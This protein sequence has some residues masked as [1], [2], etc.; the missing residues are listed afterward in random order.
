M[1]MNF[2]AVISVVTS[3][4]IYFQILNNKT[5]TISI[6][7][8][9][10][11]LPYSI[12]FA[13]SNSFVEEVI[14]RLGLVVTLK[15]KVKDST[16]CYLSAVIFGIAHYGGNPGGI[17]GVLVTG[18]LGWFLTKSILE[19]KGLFWAWFIHF[20]QDVIIFTALMAIEAV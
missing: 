8:I 12:L 1:G 3:M 18:F 13:L 15:G 2:A 17:V 11:I 14:T 16:I 9:I 19:T 4:V 5:D 10:K 6:L 7:Q 20:L